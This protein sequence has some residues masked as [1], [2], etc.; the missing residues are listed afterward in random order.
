MTCHD[1]T[2]HQRIHSLQGR[3]DFTGCKWLNLKLAVS[4][5]GD[6]FGDCF[7]CAVE[8]IERLWKLDA[9]RRLVDELFCAIAGFFAAVAARPMPA[10]CRIDDVS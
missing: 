10:A 3:N 1:C 4:R 9:S 2:V 6:V 5:L 7:T 8:R